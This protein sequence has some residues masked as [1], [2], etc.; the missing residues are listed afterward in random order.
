MGL[1]SNARNALTALSVEGHMPGFER[2]SGW[3]NSE[4]I[5]ADD[6]GGKVVLADFCTYTCINWL[7]TLS[8]VRAWAEKY[9]DHAGC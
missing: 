8:Y 6:L 1:F 2:A 9:G 4:P 3:L 5:T 7:R